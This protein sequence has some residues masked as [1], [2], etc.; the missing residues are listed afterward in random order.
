MAIYD[1]ATEV[2]ELTVG[3]STIP[4]V[5]SANS[6]D[7]IDGNDGVP[8]LFGNGER[9]FM[10][11]EV[12]EAFAPSSGDT[13]LAN[14]GVAIS[15]TATLGTDSHVLALTGG[16]IAGD[17]VGFDA[18]DLPLGKLFHLSIPPW[19]DLLET[20]DSVW[21]HPATLTSSMLDTF[22]G[23]RYMGI[24]I[25]VPNSNDVRGGTDDPY[26]TAGKVKARIIK[27]PAVSKL[28]A[29][30]NVYGSRMAVL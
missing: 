20:T 29:L 23:L 30:S 25:S 18:G 15:A 6:I 2:D 3:G 1:F 21:P 17:F 11:F 9:L 24:I 10:Q 13:P 28:T 14:F 7:L 12:T 27:E 4:F 5:Y 8:A 26:F 22:R 19:E 16:S